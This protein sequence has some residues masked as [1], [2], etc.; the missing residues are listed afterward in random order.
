[1]KKTKLYFSICQRKL[2]IK[3]ALPNAENLDPWPTYDSLSSIS[4]FAKLH[5]GV[6]SN[7]T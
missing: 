6:L 5:E 3:V 4:R 2:Y 1:M 7:D